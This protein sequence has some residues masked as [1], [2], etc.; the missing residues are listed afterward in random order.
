MIYEV[1]GDILKSRANAI[2]HGVS[3]ADHF[4]SGLALSLRDM[5]PSLYKDYRH[6]YQTHHPKEGEAWTWAGADGKRVINLLTQKSGLGHSA[7]PG[8][9]SLENVNRTLKELRKI[10][11]NENL[12]SVAL[13]KLA[14]GVG[15]LEWEDV[16]P[17]IQKHL[18]DVS[19]KI[20][21]YTQF[22]K[23]VEAKEN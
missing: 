13:P 6:Y 11:E 8:K 7:I 14:C 22:Q 21:I 9:A 5:W 2:A 18:G 10:I 3:P 1:S 4:N 17:L 15:G 23:G 16:Y 20:F 12:N 19:A